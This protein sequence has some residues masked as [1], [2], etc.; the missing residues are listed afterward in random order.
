MVTQWI[1][2]EPGGTIVAEAENQSDVMYWFLYSG[3]VSVEKQRFNASV[4]N[5]IIYSEASQTQY[6]R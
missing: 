3:M 1:D 4:A 6:S 5:P 2:V